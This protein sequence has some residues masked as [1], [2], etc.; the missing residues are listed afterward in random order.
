MQYAELS[1]R[2]REGAPVKEI[3]YKNLCGT[4]RAEIARY[5]GTISDEKV[6]KMFL[7]CFF[8]SLDTAAKR[9][10][11]GSTFMLTGDIPA[12]WLRDSA[13]QV[14]G[15]LPYCKEDDDVRALITG[16]LRRQFYYIGL[17]P[18]A[19]AFNERP[20]N[21]GHKD[22]VT[23]WDSPWIWERKFEL[24]SLCY[25]LWLLQK[26][27]DFT[28]DYSPADDGFRFALDRILDTLETEQNH[29]EKSKYRH[30]R[31]K[32][33]EF[34]TLP[35]GRKGDARRL[36]GPGLERL[37]SQRRRVQVRIS[38]SVQYVC[39]GGAALAGRTCGRRGNRR[40]KEPHRKAARA[41]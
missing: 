21:H 6:R 37:P 23:D 11:D 28:G 39:G 14:T 10:P 9:L 40:Q 8:S 2:G 22:D 16:L 41:D 27:V 25:P 18:Y 33:P 1:P 7:T 38:D 19:N 17:D 20:N 30:S 24:D 15:Y 34:P 31:P 32:Y 29:G 26:Y 3:Y 35:N 4:M 5:A 13:V 12:M 36:Y